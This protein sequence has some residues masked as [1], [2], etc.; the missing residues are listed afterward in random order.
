MKYWLNIFTGKAILLVI[1]IV[2]GVA[3]VL[4]FAYSYVAGIIFG[5]FLV[6]AVRALIGADE[7]E[8]WVEKLFNDGNGPFK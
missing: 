2:L 4:G 5:V 8:E 7:I 6:I 1:V 3:T